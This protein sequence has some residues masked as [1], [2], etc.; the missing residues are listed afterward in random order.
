[1]LNPH[2][3]RTAVAAKLSPT[4]ITG[5]DRA[6]IIASCIREIPIRAIDIHPF[7]SARPIAQHDRDGA[8]MVGV[9]QPGP[10]D[11]IGMIEVI[12]LQAVSV[13]PS[14]LQQPIERLPMRS[15]SRRAVIIGLEHAG[16]AA[17]P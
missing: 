17:F 14:H 8:R 13:I 6:A 5:G 11:D 15:T 2:R 3:H 4:V 12:V 9:T 16:L 7:R 1:M 10:A